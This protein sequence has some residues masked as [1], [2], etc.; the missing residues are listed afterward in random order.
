MTSPDVPT[1]RA[2][3][4]NP[5]SF[6]RI[7]VALNN[8]NFLSEALR[9]PQSRIHELD[10]WDEYLLRGYLPSKH[11]DD[12]VVDTEMRLS[13]TPLQHISGRTMSDR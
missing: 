1:L 13:C 3:I 4:A 2:L 10:W 8:A 9:T 5:S 11:A 6:A 12:A 7:F